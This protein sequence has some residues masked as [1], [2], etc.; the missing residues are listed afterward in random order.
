LNNFDDFG[1]GFGDFGNSGEA[2]EFNPGFGGA[3]QPDQQGQEV[4]NQFEFGEQE[5]DEIDPFKFG[6]SEES[7]I[8]EEEEE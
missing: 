6:S 3:P 5:E 7:E 2:Q 1:G 8:S 4:V